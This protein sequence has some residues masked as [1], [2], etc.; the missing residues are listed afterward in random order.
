VSAE[1]RDASG[2]IR[3]IARRTL[4]GA[5]QGDPSSGSPSPFRKIGLTCEGHNPSLAVGG[6]AGNALPGCG[7]D[8]HA[9]L[10]GASNLYFP[11]VVS[12]IYIPEIDD[13]GLSPEL[14]ELLDD[15]KLKMALLA[16]AQ[17]SGSGL[18]TAKVAKIALK[19]HFPESTVDPSALADAANRHTL[20]NAIYDNRDVRAYLDQKIQTAE[21]GRLSVAMLAT[22]I[23]E[24]F[25]DWEIDPSF[26]VPLLAPRL[27]GKAN[28]QSSD[29]LSQDPLAESAYRHQE[30]RVFCRDVQEG[31]PKT[32]LLIKSHPIAGYGDIVAESFDRV[33]LLHKL[34]ETKA[35]VGYSRIFPDNDLTPAQRWGLF[36]S[37]K[38]DWL[39]AT[40]VRGEGIFLRFR[41]ERLAAWLAEHGHMHERRLGPL[42]LNLTML[43]NRRNQVATP[44]RPK[45][46]LIHTFAHLI[47][48][49]LVYECG[50]GS[51]S[52]RER[53]YASD[54]DNKMSGVL[55][56]TAAGDSEGTMGG[57]VKMGGPSYLEGVIAKALERARWCSSDPVCIESSGQGPDSCNLGACHSCALL[58]ETSCEEQNRLLDRGVVIGTLERPG[59]GYFLSAD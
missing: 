22:A 21:D 11:R 17:V 10:R 15:H 14:L 24:I 59:T 45:Y 6:Q 40:I 37:R 31:F 4:G 47:I 51:A 35:Y 42:N 12:S 36:S 32:N 58:P 16:G 5:F 23:H 39:P 38:R 30:Y 8:L 55:I 7:D 27:E 52:L 26:L 34:R 50:Y 56:Y 19:Q 29:G 44:A 46:V 41:E 18:V 20:P 25:E 13:D 49:Q 53:I 2:G 43:R 1:E 54:D 28:I 9:L 57:L 48:N 33:S 3:V